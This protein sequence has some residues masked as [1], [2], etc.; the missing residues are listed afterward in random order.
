MRV[1]RPIWGFGRWGWA[2]LPIAIGLT[3]CICGGYDLRLAI[4][5]LWN[6][7]FGWRSLI[8]TMIDWTIFPHNYSLQLPLAGS[9]T[10]I[11][12]LLGMYLTP[13][14]LAWWVW[15]GVI[16]WLLVNPVVWWQAR[17]WSVQIV[18]ASLGSVS[19][20]DVYLALQLLL[21][22]VFAGWLAHRVK[23][24]L[25]VLGVG[26]ASAALDRLMDWRA[27]NQPTG[28]A[29]AWLYLAIEVLWHGSVSAALIGFAA[30]DYWRACREAWRC[31]LCGYDL[32]GLG[33]SPGGSP[34]CPECG[35]K[36]PV[37]P[38]QALAAGRSRPP[39]HP[40][41]TSSAP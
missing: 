6:D 34:V 33:V 20:Q 12:V 39:V 10:L 29:P 5:Q 11:P 22:A 16:L 32:T 2:L 27:M 9:L 24:G 19:N 23:A 38:A 28:P 25:M 8:Y 40:K 30:I 17:T 13:R 15:I 31:G 3:Y 18:P 41:P 26:I 21:F 4:M 37:S 14:P 35:G 1:I 7:W 36:K